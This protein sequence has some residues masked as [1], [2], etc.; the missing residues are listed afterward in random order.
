MDEFD[1][2]CR[3]SGGALARRDE[4][5]L[6]RPNQR[7]PSDFVKARNR[8]DAHTV[9]ACNVPKRVARFYDVDP[10]RLRQHGVMEFGPRVAPDDSVDDEPSLALK[11]LDRLQRIRAKH[12]VG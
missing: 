2:G 4:E 1:L 10:D 6:P 9:G 3:T 5:L 8:L 7:W 11:L 12:P